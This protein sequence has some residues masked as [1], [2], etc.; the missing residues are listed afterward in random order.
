[1]WNKEC[2]KLTKEEA[3]E[4]QKLIDQLDEPEPG[5]LSS[6]TDALKKPWIVIIEILLFIIMLILCF[7]I[8]IW[9]GGYI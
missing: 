9:L 8:W 6:D 7:Y 3:A 2:R 1:M 5:E 4:I